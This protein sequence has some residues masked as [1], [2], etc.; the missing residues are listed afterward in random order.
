MTKL[1]GAIAEQA[2]ALQALKLG[3]GVLKPLGDRLPYDLVFDVNNSLIKVQVKN[4]WKDTKGA[5]YV[6]DARRTKTNRR[7]ML[8]EYYSEQDFDFLIAYIMEVD[9]FYVLPFSVYNEYSSSI[10]LA[11]D[12]RT[13]RF[14]RTWDELSKSKRLRG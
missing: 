3:Y 10:H 4:A 12:N 1:K 2:V 5:S 6:I 13:S 14:P 11:A 8:R 9:L 7:R